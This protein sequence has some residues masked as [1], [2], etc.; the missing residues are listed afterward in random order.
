MSTSTE[1]AP[2]LIAYHV[3]ENGDKTFWTRVGAAWPNK[4]GGFQVRLEA[5]PVNGELVLL[6]P[7]AKDEDA[8]TEEGTGA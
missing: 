7:R 8:K 6:P 4:K 3:T 1:N 2:A 5:V